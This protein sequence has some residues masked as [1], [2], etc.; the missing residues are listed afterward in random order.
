MERRRS[1]VLPSPA[2]PALLFERFWRGGR[3]SLMLPGQASCIPL[4]E[5]VQSRLRCRYELPLSRLFLPSVNRNKM[6]SGNVCVRVFES[7]RCINSPQRHCC[8]VTRNTPKRLGFEE[9]SKNAQGL[10]SDS[11]FVHCNNVTWMN[12]R[13]TEF[14]RTTGVTQGQKKQRRAP[15]GASLLAGFF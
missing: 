14:L 3:I 7:R 12:S 15:E 4:V 2:Y 9:P 1:S 10:P 6:P 13:W 8:G 5:S 11:E